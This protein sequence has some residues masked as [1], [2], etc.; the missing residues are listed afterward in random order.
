MRCV[1]GQDNTL[2]SSLRSLSAS[3]HRCLRERAQRLEDAD[4]DRLGKRQFALEHR[5]PRDAEHGER[6]EDA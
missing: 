3:R 6:P 1:A 2:S 4:R 5:K